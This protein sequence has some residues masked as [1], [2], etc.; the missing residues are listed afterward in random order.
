MPPYINTQALQISGAKNTI[1]GIQEMQDIV[2]F[3]LVVLF[4]RL[5]GRFG[6]LAAIK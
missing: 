4:D 3:V 2:R 6:L 1:S 5:A